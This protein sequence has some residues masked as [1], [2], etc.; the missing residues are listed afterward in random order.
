MKLRDLFL[1]VTLATALPAHA[2]LFDDDEARRRIDQ[3]RQEH[4]ARLQKLEAATDT[5]TRA[6]LDLNAQI[7]RLRQEVAQLRGQAE[8]LTNS[9][10][11]TSKRQQDFYV[12]LDTR[13]RRLETA[14]VPVADASAPSAAASEPRAA[15][16]AQ[17]ARDY[18]AAINIMRGGKYAEAVVAFKKFIQTWPRSNFQSGAHFWTGAALSQTKDYAG[19]KEFYARL[20]QNWPQDALAPDALLGQANAEQA[21]G[22]AKTSRATLEKLV[23]SYPDSEAAKTARQ[24][25]KK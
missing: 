17:E 16:P 3:L 7:E 21:A 20:V 5:N 1:A 12:D 9:G 18:E 25:L 10:D 24:R 15:D 14:A 4:E 22:A 8:L 19:A 13:L 6:I 23:A 11:Q 2:A